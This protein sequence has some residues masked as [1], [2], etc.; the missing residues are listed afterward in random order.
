MRIIHHTTALSTGQQQQ[1]VDF[2]KR[3]PYNT[4]FQSPAFFHFYIKAKH[5]AP[6]YFLLF[7]E[8]DRLTGVLLAVVVREGKGLFSLL[9]ART[10]VYGGPV[11]A[12]DDQAYYNSMLQTLNQATARASL[13]TQFRNFRP[14]P[15]PLVEVFKSNGFILRDRLNLIAPIPSSY[16]AL[17]QMSASR[18]RHLKKGLASGV[19]VREAN[20]LEDIR[21]LYSLLQHL[22][23][24]K[25]RKPL[26]DYSFFKL[27][28]E[29]LMQQGTGVILLVCLNQK[30]IGG[31]VAPITKGLTIAELYIVGL[32]KEYPEHYPSIVATWSAME[33]AARH[34]IN[35]FDFMGLGK[36]D[37]PYGVRDFKLRF[38]GLQVN[39]GRFARRNYKFLYMLAEIGYNV[40]RHFKKV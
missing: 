25:V 27:F 35:N 14:W 20:S 13:F 37:I 29:D 12:S 19:E 24:H 18:R 17:M 23:R 9:S 32:D 30:I 8:S 5:H 39:Y 3:H 34:N 2:L 31:I 11:I 22:Y 15:E 6:H 40:L 33:Y 28:F 10:L 36:P 4:V 7:D 16:Q 1:I 38:G 21:Q 26:P